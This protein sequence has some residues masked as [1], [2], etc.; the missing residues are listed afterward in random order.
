MLRCS[1]IVKHYRGSRVLH[2]VSISVKPGEMTALIGPSG[3]GKSTVLRI[4]AC[5]EA[6]ESGTIAIDDDEYCYPA[7]PGTPAPQPWPRLTAVFQQLFLWPHMTLRENITLPLRLRQI[8]DIDK[9]VRALIERFDMSEFIDRY[10]NQVSGG[11]RQR[12]AIARALALKPVYLLLDEITS[13]LDVE[14]AAAI[15]K[16]LDSLKADN[17][18]ILM[19][20]HYLGFLQRSADQIIFMEDGKV[21]ENGGREILVNPK[22]SGM[23]RFLSSFNEIESTIS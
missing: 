15:I 23:Q 14:Q 7:D 10:P 9:R 6:P 22:S 12:A 8:P 2:N 17:I 5:L 4:L 1:N 11:Q 16:H 18:G 21:A 13:A 3:A 19:I 20:T